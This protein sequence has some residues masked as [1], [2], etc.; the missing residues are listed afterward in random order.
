MTEQSALSLLHVLYV[1]DEE[2]TRNELSRFLKRRVSH[3]DTATNGLQALIEFENHPPDV[4]IT[5]LRMPDMDGLELTKRVRELGYDTPIIVTSALS[6]SDTILTAVDRGIIKYIVKPIDVEELENALFQVADDVLSKRHKFVADRKILSAEDR[7]H[8]EKLLARDL[9]SLLK[10]TTG[11][12]PR[13]LRVKLSIEHA[14]IHVEGMLTPMEHTLLKGAQSPE[15]LALNRE[16]L[17]KTLLQDIQVIFET[18]TGNGV[19]I[20]QY[21]GRTREDKE[22]IYLTFKRR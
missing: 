6:D 20:S 1:E 3:L 18:H 10:R 17:Y 5:D 14:Q 7:Q 2:L 8:I 11:K 9:S 16:L 22:E 15:A 21:S 13:K 12:G 19:L 4:L